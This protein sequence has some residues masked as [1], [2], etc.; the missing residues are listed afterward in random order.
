MKKE[1]SKWTS[2]TCGVV[3]LNTIQ[4]LDK[5]VAA[6]RRIRRSRVN[7]LLFL[8]RVLRWKGLCLYDLFVVITPT[9]DPSNSFASVMGGRKRQETGAS[10]TEWSKVLRS[11]RSVFARVGSSPTACIFLSVDSLS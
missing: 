5:R 11:G 6:I 1:R 3:F 2:R 7:R 4:Q 10:V 9:D 8:I